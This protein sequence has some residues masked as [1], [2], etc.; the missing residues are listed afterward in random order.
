[1][2]VRAGQQK[3]LSIEELRPLN[4]GARETLDSF[5]ESKEIQLVNPKKKKKKKKKKITLNIHW[6]D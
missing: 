1:M 6:K 5:L 2:D 3:R 4:C